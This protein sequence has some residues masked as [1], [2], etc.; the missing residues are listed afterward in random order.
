MLYSRKKQAERPGVRHWVRTLLLVAVT[1]GVTWYSQSDRNNPFT[2]RYIIEVGTRTGIP[3]IACIKDQFP[4]TAELL[5]VPKDISLWDKE[6]SS[7]FDSARVLITGTVDSPLPARLRI[8]DWLVP[9]CEDSTGLSGASENAPKPRLFRIP[10][11]F[12]RSQIRPVA[13]QGHSGGAV[14]IRFAKMRLIYI[15]SS[16]SITSEHQKSALR[17]AFDIIVTN[18]SFSYTRQLRNLLRPLEIASIGQMHNG[19]TQDSLTGNISYARVNNGMIQ[20]HMDSREQMHVRRII[21]LA[22]AS[23][24]DSNG[25]SDTTPKK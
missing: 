12:G 1:A 6:S 9:F 15:D 7:P 19:E 17:E 16:I 2:S 25:F 5:F 14:A 11:D 8:Q 10:Q 22:T 3:Y 23:S 18:G 20:Y 24:G 4:K 21:P 13:V